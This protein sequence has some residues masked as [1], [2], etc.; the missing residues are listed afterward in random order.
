[1]CH[2]E[3][4]SLLLGSGGVN[5]KTSNDKVGVGAGQR[6]WRE[7]GLQWGKVELMKTEEG[8]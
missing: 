2:L 5:V 6:Q 4:R 1:M 7:V 8:V 3:K